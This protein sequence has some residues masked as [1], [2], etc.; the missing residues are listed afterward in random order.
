[1]DEMFDVV[2]VGGGAA[3]LSGAV[4][5]ARFRRSVLVLDAGDAR[6]APAGHVHN[7]LTRDGMPP[8]E[9]YEAGRAEVRRYGGRVEQGRVTAVRREGD[10]LRIEM[11]ERAVMARRVLVATG[12]RDEL[13][14]IPGLAERWG[15]DVVHCP[16]CHGWEVRDQNIGVLA[17]GPMAVHQALLFRQLS[18]RVTLLRHT[19]PAPAD[20][21]LEQLHVLGIGVVEG[22]VVKVESGVAGL[23]G[24]RLADG[25]QVQ[26]DALVVTPGVTARAELLAP[27]GLQPAE[28]EIGGHVLG[29]RI[30]A[31]AAG[32]TAAAGVRVAGNVTDLLAQ[33]VSSAA[34]GLNAA[35]AINADL[36]AEGAA[37]ALEAH[38]HAQVYGQE[39]W[40]ERYR[41]KPQIWSGDPNAVLV[42]EVG[43]LTP[44]T[45]L[46]AG[47]GEGADALWL[48]ARGWHVTAAELSTVALKRAA[49]QSDRLGLHVDW[50]HLDLTS[51]PAKGTFDLVT[52]FFL[53]LPATSRQS[54]WR[55]LA[56]AVA[57]GGT[58]L[59]VGHDLSD[60]ATMPRPRLAEMGWTIGE[61]A[62]SLGEGW[63]V[64]VAE[65]RPRQATD[66]DGREVTIHD[67]VLR[68][69]R[70]L[71]AGTGSAAPALAVDGAER[72][73][74]G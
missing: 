4:A 61:V 63:A 62:G 37:A 38:R 68:A 12:A 45:A 30:E 51:E 47:S 69:R 65:A 53:H 50:Q 23:T 55:H 59:V 15:T 1:M 21:E 34:A 54:L 11:G 66:P 39:A 31:D 74:A 58:L 46:D 57:P 16:Y 64:E 13:P 8:A 48:A 28:V 7:F 17:T 18:S 25:S 29:S 42:A 43:G 19:G 14:G 36:V 10:R 40:D 52:A 33:V 26:L 9:M 41:S 49:A 60:M 27:L 3:G 67:A 56:A 2:V 71:V 20:E 35:A 24:V 72:Q 70:D 5:L 22:E 73:L 32:A 44:G 6:N